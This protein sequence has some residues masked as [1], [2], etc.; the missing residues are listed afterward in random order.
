MSI[1]ADFHLRS[2]A[3]T[4]ATADCISSPFLIDHVYGLRLLIQ[5]EIVP[6][7]KQ[8]LSRGAA[9]PL[10]VSRGWLPVCECI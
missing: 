5:T 7:N 10:R 3:H 4:V 2:R 9:Q 6:V 1:R 8:R